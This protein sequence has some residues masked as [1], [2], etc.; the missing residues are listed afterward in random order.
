MHLQDDFTSQTLVKML[1]LGVSGGTGAVCMA[2]TLLA[3][4][5]LLVILAALG[6]S[7]MLMYAFS[8]SF[9]FLVLQCIPIS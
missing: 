3:Q 1:A 5:P 9:F 2:A 6:H 8:F 4:R 7:T